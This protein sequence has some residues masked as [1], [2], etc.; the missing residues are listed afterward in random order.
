MTPCGSPGVVARGCRAAAR[1]AIVR[2]MSRP[3]RRLGAAV[4]ALA[5]ALAWLGA[6]RVCEAMGRGL[7]AVSVEA[8]SHALPGAHAAHH[9]AGVHEGAQPDHQQPVPDPHAPGSSPER[10]PS[11]VACGLTAAPVQVAAGMPSAVPEGQP[12]STPATRR[13]APVV[14]PELPP[15]RA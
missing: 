11:S 8:P 7:A 2:R 14:A 1:T 13:D 5:W 6:G 3:P 10:C 9:G 15:P 12:S 4:L